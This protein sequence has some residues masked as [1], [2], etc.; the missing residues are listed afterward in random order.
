MADRRNEF[1]ERMRNR[2]IGKSMLKEEIWNDVPDKIGKSM[3]GQQFFF[4]EEARA[5]HRVGIGLGL[6][7]RLPRYVQR[8]DRIN[9]IQVR[10]G[11][12]GLLKML[13]LN[14]GDEPSDGSEVIT[15]RKNLQ[16]ADL[17]GNYEHVMYGE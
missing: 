14:T 12:K 3:G 9:H 6:G 13:F 4:D 7:W 16:Y 11:E 2:P 17:R 10:L 8:K 15:V 5:I 1:A